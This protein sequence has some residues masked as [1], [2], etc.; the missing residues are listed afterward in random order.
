MLKPYD[1][2]TERKKYR[3]EKENEAIEVKLYYF[4]HDRDLYLQEINLLN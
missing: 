2:R 4:N 3:N 1:I